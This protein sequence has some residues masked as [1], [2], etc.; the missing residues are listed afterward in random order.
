MKATI[1]IFLKSL[2]EMANNAKY[3]GA[4]NVDCTRTRARLISWMLQFLE[5]LQELTVGAKG[6]I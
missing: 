6:G 2:W 3:N 1:S 5:S 4:N